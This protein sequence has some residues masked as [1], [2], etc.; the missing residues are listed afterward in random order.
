MH[1]LAEAWPL[2]ALRVRNGPTELRLPDE[3]D[4]AALAALARDGIHDPAQMPF[5]YP[6]TDADPAQRATSVAQWAWRTRADWMPQKWS[7]ELVAVEDDQVV[8]TQGIKAHDFAITREFETGS[9][10]GRRHQGRGVATRMRQAVL[11]LGFAGLGAQVG[12]SAAFSDN[13][14]SLHISEKLGYRWDGTSRQARRG[15]PAEMIRLVLTRADW[16][17]TGPPG[18]T[19]D[20]LESCES[21]FGLPAG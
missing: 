20:G 8:G 2:F 16:Q 15:E 21:W 14:A 10:V 4:L 3:A 12:R 1:P 6:W 18:V 11:H 5:S 7:L 17:A 19:I 13:A 9:W